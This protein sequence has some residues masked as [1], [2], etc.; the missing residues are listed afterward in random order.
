M[1]SITVRPSKKTPG[2]FDITAAWTEPDL[3]CVDETLYGVK[4]D[5]W[6]FLTLDGM[7]AENLQETELDMPEALEDLYAQHLKGSHIA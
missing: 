7:L 2:A 6:L 5:K 4:L 1:K 3:T